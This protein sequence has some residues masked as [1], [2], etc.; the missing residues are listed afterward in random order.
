M[1][2][3][4]ADFSTEFSTEIHPHFC[5]ID[6]VCKSPGLEYRATAPGFVIRAARDNKSD[7][8]TVFFFKEDRISHGDCAVKI[9]G[10]DRLS[11]EKCIIEA[12]NR[13]GSLNFS[14]NTDLQSTDFGDQEIKLDTE[15]P[16]IPSVFDND[17]K[18]NVYVVNVGR[19]Y[20]LMS[21]KYKIGVW[22]KDHNS[23]F[24]ITFRLHNGKSKRVFEVDGKLSSVRDFVI[25]AIQN[26]RYIWLKNSKNKTIRRKKLR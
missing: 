23:N 17:L 20:R 1:S 2:W 19:L 14:D 13:P 24:R 18:V 4:E 21:K 8:F 3:L 25:S 5:G 6:L 10:H 26:P 22:R 15:W 9:A 11:I 16:A 12:K 7:K